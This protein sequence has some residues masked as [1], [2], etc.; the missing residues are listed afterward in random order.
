MSSLPDSIRHGAALATVA[1]AVAG[2]ADAPGPIYLERRGDRY[3]WSLTHRGG[4]YPLLR[5]TAKM[6]GIDYHALALPSR[7]LEGTPLTIVAADPRLGLPEAHALLEPPIAPDPM[8]LADQIRA[9]L[10]H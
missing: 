6:L 7:A 9:A 5:E 8:S 10:N 3:R 1:E 2:A 4:P